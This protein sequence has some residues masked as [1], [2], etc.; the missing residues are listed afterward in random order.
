VAFVS[1]KLCCVHPDGA[2]ELVTRGILNLTH[3][4]GHDE[5][6]PL[7]PGEPVAV[8]FDLDA[9]AFAFPAGS[10]IRLDLA[11]SDF[12]SS[13]PPPEAGTTTVDP[14]SSRLLLPV[15][16]PASLAS[17][18]FI[19]GESDPHRPD[20]VLWEVREDVV[21]G[22]KRVVIDHGGVRGQ[23]ASGVE[24]L[25]A[26]GGEV[27]VR[28]DEPAD[29]WGRGG[30]TYELAWPDVT[31]RTESRGSLRTDATTWYLELELDVFE[32]DVSVAH[33]TWERTAPRH[34]Q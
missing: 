26:Y 3:R 20:R 34:L 24:I 30:T 22:A 8:A 15:V 21:T 11:G 18:E 31:V 4:D 13:W 27:G 28:G 23:G 12:A 33:R 32:N 16:P 7:V 9:T 17:P 10:T 19:P 25:D 5:M 29:A 1:A 6:R 2:S 14:S